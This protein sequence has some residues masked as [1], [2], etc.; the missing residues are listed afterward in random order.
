MK[1]KMLK[2]FI[3]VN[4]ILFSG[5]VYSDEIDDV[6]Q[7]QLQLG[8]NQRLDSSVTPYIKAENNKS[9]AFDTFSEIYEARNIN[10]SV[11]LSTNKQRYKISNDG[12]LDNDFVDISVKSDRDG[13]L[14]ILMLGTDSEQIV[15]LLPNDEFVD[16]KIYRGK[17]VTI[18]SKILAM[19]PSGTD[20]LLAIISD[21]PLDYK[22]MDLE[23]A[24]PYSFMKSNDVGLRNLKLLT[25]GYSII[26]SKPKLKDKPKEKAKTNS[27]P[28]EIAKSEINTTFNTKNEL[29]CAE[30]KARNLKYQVDIKSIGNIDINK[31]CGSKYGASMISIE[32]YD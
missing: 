22:N 27:K 24:G 18:K 13:Y 20:H 14:Y 17:P 25:S 1:V 8:E 32:E 15:F 11:T 6:I 9:S 4:F 21:N 29:Y 2:L 5:F 28:K 3:V 10:K 7:E 19:G 16:N 12:D 30:S 23:K 26:S 31:E